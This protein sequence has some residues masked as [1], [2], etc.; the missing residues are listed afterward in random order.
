MP[1]HLTE[2]VPHTSYIHTGRGGAGNRTHVPPPSTHASSTNYT[3]APRPTTNNKPIHSGRGGAGNIHPASERAIFSFD[4]ELSRERITPVYHVGRGGVGN[5]VDERRVSNES[6]T[7]RR[8]G[9]ADSMTSRE[10][11][12]SDGPTTA[13]KSVE[14]VRDRVG[15]TF[16]RGS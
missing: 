10:S 15:R 1:F 12:G 4:E 3:P 7:T 11:A 9:S 14:W 8:N 2:P 5:F 13:R 16:S 6:G